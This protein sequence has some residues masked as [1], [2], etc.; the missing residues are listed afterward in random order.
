MSD[1]VAD[2]LAQ[3][4]TERPD[5]DTTPMAVVGRLSRA[6]RRLDVELAKTF[7]AHDLDAASFDVL[8]TLRRSGE[9][10]ALAPKQLSDAAMITTG[11]VTQ[12]LDKLEQR[13]M[14]R[15]SQRPGDGRGVLVHLTASGRRAIDAALPDHLHTEQR[16]LSALTARQQ[17]DLANLLTVLLTGIEDK[18]SKARRSRSD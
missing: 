5:L 6:A 11:A 8:A 14:V 13:G 10:F 16:L 3:W 2:I 9:P 4:A 18:N 12:R 15:R 1:H 17:R 7:A